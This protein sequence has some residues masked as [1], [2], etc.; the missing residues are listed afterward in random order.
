MPGPYDDENLTDDDL[1]ELEEHERT[2]ALPPPDSSDEAIPSDEE[3]E[4]APA[5]DS[6][7]APAAPVADDDAGD[8]DAG[9]DPREELEG[10]LAK[11]KGKST[12]EL[13]RLA[14]QQ[15]KRANRAEFDSRTSTA[16]L[17]NVLAKIQEKRDARV[18]ALKNEREQFKQKVETDPDAALLEAHER[19]LSE[20]ERAELQQL[21]AEEFEARAS[22]AIELA[23]SVI[24]DFQ[25]RAP[26]IRGFGVELGFS[27]QEVDGIVDGRQIVALH[28]A[29]IAGNMI[30]AGIIDTS[31]RFTAL[32]E[33]AV[34]QAGNAPPRGSGFNRAPARASNGGKTLEQQLAD[35]DQ[36]DDAAFD[37]LSDDL[38]MGLLKQDA[39]R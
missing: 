21:D 3:G 30:R 2:G 1:K 4:A 20:Q 12:E 16:N 33:S 32:P 36:M 9:D 14:F 6:K 29:S 5:A 28:L 38:V 26:Q 10:F 18:N 31:G 19:N 15:Q 27:P 25:T 17:Q 37:A 23:S 35:L 34:E 7:P 8:D 24:P 11:H 22:A 39:S 13:L